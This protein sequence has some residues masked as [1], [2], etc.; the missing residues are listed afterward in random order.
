MGKGWVSETRVLRT[1]SGWS[2]IYFKILIFDSYGG[3]RI[4][5][6]A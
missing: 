3:E 1:V 2:I 4:V 5:D 6:L